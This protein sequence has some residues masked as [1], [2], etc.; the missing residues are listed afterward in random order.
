MIFSDLLPV[1][2]HVLGCFAIEMG[3]DTHYD[4]SHYFD[5]KTLLLQVCWKISSSATKTGFYN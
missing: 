4:F 5:V 2:Y 1:V 3:M